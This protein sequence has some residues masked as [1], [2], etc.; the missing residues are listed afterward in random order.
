MN[1]FNFADSCKF[2]LKV[3]QNVLL[4]RQNLLSMIINNTGDR[5]HDL[6]MFIIALA[7]L[8]ILVYA[9]LRILLV[10][11]MRSDRIFFICILIIIIIYD[12]PSISYNEKTE[13]FEFINGGIF[14]RSKISKRRRNHSIKRVAQPPSRKG[15]I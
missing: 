11:I 9:A 2:S 13:F 15:R 3:R 5:S 6:S 12:I 7:F 1:F 14:K 8:F 10:Y 4:T